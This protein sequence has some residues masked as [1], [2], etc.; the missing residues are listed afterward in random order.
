MGKI[1][2][3]FVKGRYTVR[4]SRAPQ[5]RD[6]AEALRALVFRGDLSRSDRD[7]FDARC[8]H[9]LVHDATSGTLVCC[10]RLLP[11]EAGAE[12]ANSYAA[13]FY[14]L[15]GLAGYGGKMLE[16]GRFCIGPGLTDP[17]IL[18][19]AWGA[20]TAFVDRE[21]VELLFGC[22]SFAGLDAARYAA[23]FAL[24]NENHLA[25]TQW[26]PGPKARETVALS[27]QNRPELD[28]KA[29]TQQLPALLRTY[30]MMGGWVS[31]HAVIDR[32]LGTL[33]V[34]TAVEIAAIPPARKRL[35]RALAA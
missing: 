7:A 29:A 15:S 9:A 25:P 14:D 34:F 2:Q 30:L 12:I 21:Q 10:F 28:A 5:D 27:A 18:R 20:L 24:L 19:A 35:L 16:L 6:A 31:D 11:M 17:D 13:Q 33:H 22:S 4:F 3:G 32:D 26:R 23:G 8:L 1:D